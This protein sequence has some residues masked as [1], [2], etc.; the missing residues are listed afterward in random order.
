MTYSVIMPEAEI[1]TILGKLSESYK[2]LG[3]LQRGTEWAFGPVQRAQDLCLDYVTTILPPKKF[4]TPT[5][6]T[7]F[8]FDGDDFSRIEDSIPEERQILLGVHAC[9]VEGFKFLD[10]VF[11]GFRSDPRYLRRR[12]N[13]LVFALTCKTVSD[14]CFCM[15]T[16]TGPAVTSGFDVLM[17]DIGRKYLMESGSQEGEQVLRSLGLEPSTEADFE[18]KRAVIERLKGEFKRSVDMD[19]MPE[20]CLASQDH[21]VWAK[22]GRIC[23]ACGQ[24]GMSCPTCF[25]FDVRESVDASLSKGERYREWDVCLLKE[26][27]EVALGGNFRLERSA[28]LR[29]FMCHNLSYGSYQYSMTKCIGCGRCIRIC[30]VDIDITRIARE[31]R[32][33]KGPAEVSP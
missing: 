20:L 33:E 29:Q 2:I 3:P 13:F 21:P 5:R 22:Y 27:A 31:L 9:D 8:T 16:G 11:L 26:F 19:G 30:P 10:R 7:I 15:S 32:G 25:C 12:N 18:A 4:F 17:T 23:L 28:R 14:T 24:C 6:E 1:P